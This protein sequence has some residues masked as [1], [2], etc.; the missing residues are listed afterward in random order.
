MKKT[1]HRED[2]Q[3]REGELNLG[4]KKIVS[5]EG[6]KAGKYIKDSL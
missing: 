6:M 4:K 5:K 2:R 1:G 3:D